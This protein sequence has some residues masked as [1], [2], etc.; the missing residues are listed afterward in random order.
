M[1]C[2][3]GCLGGGG[4]SKSMD[5]QFLENLIPPRKAGPGFARFR[6]ASAAAVDDLKVVT[7]TGELRIF[8]LETT[9]SDDDEV[10]LVKT[11]TRHLEPQ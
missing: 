4:E 1:A 2:V 8:E 7:P 11:L 10:M 3:G 5:P 6:M 9:K